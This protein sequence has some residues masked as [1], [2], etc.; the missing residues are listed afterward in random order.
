[1]PLLYSREGILGCVSQ[2]N[3]SNFFFG[4]SLCFYFL[5]F[6]LTQFSYFFSLAKPHLPI[7]GALFIPLI[8]CFIG[9]FVFWLVPDEDF[10]FPLTAINGINV[11]CQL[12]QVVLLSQAYYYCWLPDIVSTGTCS[13]TDYLLL[14]LGFLQSIFIIIMAFIAMFSYILFSKAIDQ[15]LTM[16]QQMEGAYEPAETEL[17]N[18]RQ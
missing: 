9:G 2:I 13:A 16:R 11:L 8:F 15:N 18:T 1:M 3:I 10:A 7:Y 12:I 14:T 6:Y 4:G 17:D 5:V